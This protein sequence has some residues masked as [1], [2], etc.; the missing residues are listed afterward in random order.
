MTEFNECPNNYKDC[1][2]SELKIFSAISSNFSKYKQFINQISQDKLAFILISLGSPPTDAEIKRISLEKSTKMLSSNKKIEEVLKKTTTEDTGNQILAQKIFSVAVGKDGRKVIVFNASTLVTSEMD[3]EK[4][5][6]ILIQHTLSIIDKPFDLLV[7]FT[8][9]GIHNEWNAD[10]LDQF[11]EHISKYK[12]NLN[13][14]LILNTNNTAKQLSKRFLRMFGSR[15]SKKTFNCTSHRELSEFIS[16]DILIKCLDETTAALQRT[17]VKEYIG[18]NRIISKVSTP[19]SM[20]LF[21]DYI[22][23][24]TVKKEELFGAQGVMVEC[25]A[26]SE[27]SSFHRVIEHSAEIKTEHWVLDIE[28]RNTSNKTQVFLEL[29]Q[30]SPVIAI[31]QKNISRLA[32]NKADQFNTP[33]MRSPDI[34]VSLL[35]ISLLNISDESG[36]VRSEGFNLLIET[37]KAFNIKSVTFLPSYIPKN[38]QQFAL[39]LSTYIANS[40]NDIGLEF[41]NEVLCFLDD[42]KQKSSVLR[43]LSPWIDNLQIIMLK[44]LD[45]STLG[46]IGSIIKMFLEITINHPEVH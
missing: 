45:D 19:V 42:T 34:F 18:I 8:R 15:T 2:V 1:L 17:P 13:N 37:L 38:T 12:G 20:Q 40:L 6:K 36:D 32:F 28:E 46:R 21:H 29:K 31:I 4:F 33:E 27:I 35:N 25:W 24:T 30:N 23:V 7:N 14:I 11:Q 5:I 39:N 22:S 3:I 43:Y 9:F 10:V 41:I 44:S 26:Y 16:S